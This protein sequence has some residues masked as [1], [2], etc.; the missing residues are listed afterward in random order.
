MFN[1]KNISRS[2]AVA[3][4]IAATPQIAEAKNFSSKLQLRDGWSIR[5]YSILGH[6]NDVIVASYGANYLY[7]SYVYKGAWF[8]HSCQ[9]HPNGSTRVAATVNGITKHLIVDKNGRI[10][11]KDLVFHNHNTGELLYPTNGFTPQTNTISG[12]LA[13]PKQLMRVTITHRG[14]AHYFIVGSLHE[15]D[16]GVQASLCSPV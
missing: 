2:I 6:A 13:K 5:G 11:G 14:K 10:H 9:R 8:S 3:L 7:K 1:I 12:L 15:K 4:V 16:M